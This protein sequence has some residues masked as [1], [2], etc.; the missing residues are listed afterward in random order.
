MPARAS[1]PTTLERAYRRALAEILARPLPPRRLGS[2][3]RVVKRKMSN[4]P[5]KRSHHRNWPQPTKTPAAAIT[6]I[7]PYVNG[8]ATK[9][10]FQPVR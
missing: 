8:I 9:P 3:P 4:Y 5:V 6:I 2:N 10:E 7:Q 1:P